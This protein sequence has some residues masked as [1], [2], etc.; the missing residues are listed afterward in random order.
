M[1]KSLAEGSAGSAAGGTGY[2]PGENRAGYAAAHRTDGAA[3]RAGNGAGFRAGQ[4]GSGAARSAGSSA[5]G[6]PNAP[7]DVALLGAERLAG[8]ARPN[9]IAFTG[10]E[11]GRFAFVRL[12]RLM[13]VAKPIQ[14]RLPRGVIIVALIVIW[15]EGRALTHGRGPRMHGHKHRA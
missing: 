14:R 15:K 2:E 3:E 4:Y 13:H 5:D 8:G 12:W 9:Q 10:A 7:C 11:A 1:I 6:A